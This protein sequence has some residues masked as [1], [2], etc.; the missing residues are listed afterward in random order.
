MQFSWQTIWRFYTLRSGARNS[1][2]RWLPL[3]EIYTKKVPNHWFSIRDATILKPYIYYI[4]YILYICFSI[5]L[6]YIFIYT[7]IWFTTT[8]GL[9]S[10][11]INT[12]VGG[13]ADIN[14]YGIGCKRFQSV[15]I[16][17]TLSLWQKLF[18][19]N[20]TL[21]LELSTKCEIMSSKEKKQMPNIIHFPA[22]F[23][24]WQILSHTLHTVDTLIWRYIATSY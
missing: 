1:P 8:K 12:E 18:S 14:F 9:G 2:F 3:P 11:G 24:I 20:N 5:F 16:N 17:V 23:S 22:L 7:H 10:T 21:L 15:Y 19:V 4:L 13:T 6:L